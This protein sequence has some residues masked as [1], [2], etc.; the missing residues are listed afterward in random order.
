M[1]FLNQFSRDQKTC[2]WISA[3]I[4]YVQHRRNHEVVGEQFEL[5]AGEVAKTVVSGDPRKR[6]N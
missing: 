1:I 6:G 4:V 2:K 3:K 5:E